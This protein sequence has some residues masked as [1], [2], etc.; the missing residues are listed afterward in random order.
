MFKLLT[1][2]RADRPN[3]EAPGAKGRTFVA[4]GLFTRPFDAREY[5][6]RQFRPVEMDGRCPIARTICTPTCRSGGA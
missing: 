3:Y 4:G 1:A 5:A 6:W 2:H